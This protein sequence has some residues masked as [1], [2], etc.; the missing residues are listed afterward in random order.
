[1]ARQPNLLA[2]IGQLK[3]DPRHGGRAV[4]GVLMIS[5]P[6]PELHRSDHRTGWCTLLA[7]RLDF[8]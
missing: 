7:A 4:E 3:Q 6:N 5:P 8:Q 1:M 2:G